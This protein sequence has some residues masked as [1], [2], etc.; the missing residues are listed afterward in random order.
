MIIDMNKLTA[1]LSSS[2]SCYFANCHCC[3]CFLDTFVNYN[4]IIALISLV[5]RS[6]KSGISHNKLRLSAR[7]MESC[8]LDFGTFSLPHLKISAFPSGFP[9]QRI[10][11]TRNFV[12]VLSSV[13]RLNSFGFCWFLWFLSPLLGWVKV[14][15]AKLTCMEPAVG[16]LL[17]IHIPQFTLVLQFTMDST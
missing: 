7:V 1:L 15:P 4:T 13:P 9:F 17:V 3:F 14:V 2:C 6:Q 5:S 11:P 10:V 16:L 12:T 8:A